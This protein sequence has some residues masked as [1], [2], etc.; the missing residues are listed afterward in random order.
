ML[1]AAMMGL[2]S[3]QNSGENKV[4]TG[5]ALP[6]VQIR[7]ED[8][9]AAY[10]QAHSEG[11][12]DYSPMF[13][14]KASI[15]PVVNAENT[16]KPAQQE[17]AVLWKDDVLPNLNSSLAASVQFCIRDSCDALDPTEASRCYCLGTAN[18]PRECDTPLGAGTL[19]MA[20]AAAA[21]CLP[22]KLNIDQGKHEYPQEAL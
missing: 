11:C 22:K 9:T 13:C 12:F 3:P 19:P 5:G 18:N 10:C 17:P 21:V 16:W 6:T 7:C 4:K 2:T 1:M 14:G 20:I 15:L 8:R